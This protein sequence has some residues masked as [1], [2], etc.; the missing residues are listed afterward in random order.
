M[1]VPSHLRSSH[2]RSSYPISSHLGHI[3]ASSYLRSLSQTFTSSLSSSGLHVLKPH[4]VFSSSDL[5]HVVTPSYLII[6]KISS[7]NY[8]RN[9]TTW[10]VYVLKTS[11]P[12]SRANRRLVLMAYEASA[13]ILQCRHVFS[14]FWLTKCSI[15]VLI[16]MTTDVSNWRLAY[17]N[18]F[19]EWFPPQAAALDR[20]EQLFSLRLLAP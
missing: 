8:Y 6:F 17:H 5:H 19:K 7:C 4:L 10:Y 2:L 18:H 1:C 20:V 13:T 9:C 16:R 12:R 11:S 3:C 15:S 14:A